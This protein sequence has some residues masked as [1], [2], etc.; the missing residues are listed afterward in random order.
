MSEMELEQL[1][2]RVRAVGRARVV[3]TQSPGDD[4]IEAVLAGLRRL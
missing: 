4:V 3:Y 2:S 1:L